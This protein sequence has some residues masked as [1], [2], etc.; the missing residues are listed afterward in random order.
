M[1]DQSQHLK[2]FNTKKDALQICSLSLQ[3]FPGQLK[4]D[5]CIVNVLDQI[6]RVPL[7]SKLYYLRILFFIL[8]QQEQQWP[9]PVHNTLSFLVH[10]RSRSCSI[11]LFLLP[12]CTQFPSVI[13]MCLIY[14]FQCRCSL[15]IHIIQC[16]SILCTYE[17]HDLHKKIYTKLICINMTEGN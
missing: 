15:K 1:G 5:F 17:P 14:C 13:L 4:K 8:D 9:S 16:I 10:A 2:L 12:L 6:P 11:H 3:S 7:T